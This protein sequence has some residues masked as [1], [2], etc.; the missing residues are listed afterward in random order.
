MAGEVKDYVRNIDKKDNLKPELRDRIDD[1]NFVQ[2]LD[3]D[4]EKSF[5]QFTESIKSS[6]TGNETKE[7]LQDRFNGWLD[8]QMKT[9]DSFRDNEVARDIIWPTTFELQNFSTATE[10]WIFQ[11]QLNEQKDNTQR[12]EIVSV[13]G[14]DLKIQ[15]YKD[16]TWGK[17]DKNKIAELFDKNFD[18]RDDLLNLL[19]KWWIDNVRRFQRIISGLDENGSQDADWTNGLLWIFWVDWRFGWNTMKAFESYVSSHE[20]ASAPEEEETVQATASMTMT[21]EPAQTTWSPAVHPEAS[22]APTSDI[23]NY[24]HD[25]NWLTEIDEA[26]AREIVQKEIEAGRTAINLHG[27]KKISTRVAVILADFEWEIYLNWLE[28]VNKYVL[29]AFRNGK[30]KLVQFSWWSMARDG[31][32]MVITLKNGTTCEEITDE[33]CALLINKPDG[34]W[35]WDGWQHW[36]PWNWS[37]PGSS[38][39]QGGWSQQWSWSQPAWATPQ[40]WWNQQWWDNRTSDV[41]QQYEWIW[42]TDEPDWYK[43][44]SNLSFEEL[45]KVNKEKDKFIKELPHYLKDIPDNKNWSNYQRE[46]MTV[47]L[48]AHFNT[49]ATIKYNNNEISI[50]DFCNELKNGKIDTNWKG[51]K[52][53]WSD[54]IAYDADSFWNKTFRPVIKNI[55]FI[56]KTET[57]WNWDV[58]EWETSQQVIWNQQW[59]DNSRI[60]DVQQQYEWIWYNTDNP[61]LQATNDDDAIQYLTTWKNVFFIAR[62]FGKRK[63]N[64]ELS[65]VDTQYKPTGT[66]QKDLKNLRRYLL[67]CKE[68]PTEVFTKIFS[69]NKDFWDNENLWK[70][71][72]LYRECRNDQN[73][74]KKWAYLKKVMWLLENYFVRW[75][76][77][78]NWNIITTFKDMYNNELLWV[79]KDLEKKDK[80]AT[81]KLSEDERSQLKE[82]GWTA[83]EAAN[84]KTQLA[85]PSESFAEFKEKYWFDSNA[86]TQ[87]AMCLCDLNAD[88]RIDSK[89]MNAKT[90]QELFILIRDA[91]VDQKYWILEKWPMYNILNFAKIKAEQDGHAN[92]AEFLKWINLNGT[93]EEIMNKIKTRP[94]TVQYLRYMLIN[95]P[96]NMANN[97]IRYGWVRVETENTGDDLLLD[98]ET[99]E[100]INKIMS[101]EKFEEIYWNAYQQLIEQGLNDTPEIKKKLRLIIA[102]ALLESSWHYGV[103]A[104][105]W[106]DLNL[107]N[108]WDIAFM[109]WVGYWPDWKLMAWVNVA[110]GKSRAL[111]KR[112]WSIISVGV[113][114]WVNFP[115]WQFVP[116]IIWS[117]WFDQMINGSRLEDSLEKRSAKFLW[118]DGNAWVVWWV[119]VRWVWL[120]YSQDKMKWL[121]ITYESIKSDLGNTLKESLKDKWPNSTD[122]TEIRTQM[123]A[124]IKT[125]LESKFWKSKD[126]TLDQAAQNIF[127]WISYYLTEIENPSQIT[128]EQKTAIIEKV[129]ENYANQWRN[130]AMS[131]LNWKTEL[132]RVRV[133]VEFLAW[134]WPIPMASVSFKKYWNLTANETVESME[135]Y[136]QRL[137]SGIWMEYIDNSVSTEWNDKWYLTAA[138][139]TYLNNKLSVLSPSGDVPPIKKIINWDKYDLQ[140]PRNLCKYA[141]ISYN[142]ELENYMKYD[143]SSDSFMVPANIKMWLLTYSRTNDGKYNLILWDFKKWDWFKD[144]DLN[145]KPEWDTTKYEWKEWELQITESAINGNEEMK[146]LFENPEFPL[147]QCVE[148]KDWKVYFKE[149]AWFEIAIER[150]WKLW[151][152]QIWI[153]SAPEYGMLQITK[154]EDGTYSATFDDSIKD[155]LTIKYIDVKKSR[156]YQENSKRD[157]DLKDT[158]DQ[159]IDLNSMFNKIETKLSKLDD[160][161]WWNYADF[162]DYASNMIDGVLDEND[163]NK[164]FDKLKHMLSNLSAN[165]LKDTNLNALKQKIDEWNLSNVE[166]TLIVDRFKMLF[167]YHI[168]LTDGQRDG[169]NL[170][171]AIS[172]RWNVYERLTWYNWET[173]PLAWQNYREKILNQLKDKTS[174]SREVWP[175]LMGMTAFY[176]YNPDWRRITEWRWYSMTEMWR[177]TV[178]WWAYEELTD[179]ASRNRFISNLNKSEA[180]KTIL[181]EAI[182]RKIQSVP[183]LEEITIN[184]DQVITLL[185]WKELDI[186]WKKFTIET[187]YMFYLLWECWNESIWV[188]LEKIIIK[189]AGGWWWGGETWEVSVDIK[190]EP[191]Y[192]NSAG[193]SI[194]WVA[195]ESKLNIWSTRSQTYWVSVAKIQKTEPDEPEEPTPDPWSDPNTPPPTPDEPEPTPDPWSDPN[196]P[197]PT[198]VPKI[199]RENTSVSTWSN[200][201]R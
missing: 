52:I 77:D 138:S 66:E 122:K 183:W 151:F 159:Y 168:S 8:R 114:W 28:E 60:S 165:D 97:I 44:L 41:Q 59:W 141:N 137:S 33:V 6:L 49:S 124:S 86:E 139:I 105:W 164:A 88:G 39:Q 73:W 35:S 173:F 82:A 7:E 3:Q 96:M 40:Q 20:I 107:W 93:D 76:K 50:N 184:S 98:K 108:A 53:V 36:Q 142:P 125:A 157:I 74:T 195:A 79:K 102:L 126:N 58:Q 154:A 109:L 180:H 67:K 179:D 163:Y 30:C 133:W 130:K 75:I 161:Q 190:P 145:S 155:K 187:K 90:W 170:S 16:E 64:P 199:P 21:Q 38:S 23:D 103:G 57:T 78:K 42:R 134:F 194:D 46:K 72:D 174:L 196:T 147:S 37:Q 111:G 54:Y 14:A 70:L 101:D 178:L 61:E 175:S 110:Y 152:P 136:Y 156:E 160:N 11:S 188:N 95:S 146:K 43:L 9:L 185:E 116:M 83:I 120:S 167:S 25:I 144:L 15:T 94:L 197:P 56:D 2:K 186:S 121:N 27:L 198:P 148:S 172:R 193:L 118:I 162:M 24:E 189:G 166:K 63:D 149:K 191:S 106:F 104:T 1:E 171:Y 34:V 181:S 140:I 84:T 32:K 68:N 129:A 177:T 22:T 99:R 51:A 182:T 176:R 123:I 45:E 135:N 26:K 13:N 69:K 150:G 71:Y 200:Y 117:L 113:S 201:D 80:K 127:G 128:D 62:R 85:L 153:L 65:I 55:E 48:K 18:R 192:E 92:T 100:A 10:L 19:K 17:V 31:D 115:E 91:K 81:K 4:V 158:F 87:F 89:D 47:L 12:T 5:Q 169:A 143:E 119:P 132:E 112:K 131:E 29:T